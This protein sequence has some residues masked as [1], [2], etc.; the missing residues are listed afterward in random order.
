MKKKNEKKTIA[1]LSQKL[2]ENSISNLDKI[3]GG[4]LGV[5]DMYNG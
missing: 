2:L 1:E 3:K 5:L 4:F